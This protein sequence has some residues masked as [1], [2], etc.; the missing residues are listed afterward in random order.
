MYAATPVILAVMGATTLISAVTLL[1]LRHSPPSPSRQMATVVL[2]L[3]ILTAMLFFF[4][5]G[6][7][8]SPLMIAGAIV[9]Q[10]M[11][12][13][14]SAT[15]LHLV[16]LF[17]STGRQPSRPATLALAYSPA[18]FIT[19]L[20]AG[21]VT[22]MPGMFSSGGQS[23]FFHVTFG[24]LGPVVAAVGSIYLIASLVLLGLI[25][26]SGASGARWEMSLIFA[27]LAV[28]F[29]DAPLA[30]QPLPGF[31]PTAVPIVF[32]S[33]VGIALA[34]AV[35]RECP[36]IVPQREQGTGETPPE[37]KFLPGS[38]HLCLHRD[39]EMARKAFASVVK[40]GVQGLWVTRKNPRDGR[41]AQGLVNTP[42][43]WLTSATVEGEVCI[44][45][46]DTGRLS[47][48]FIDFLGAVKDYII[49]FEGLE[50]ITSNIGFKGTLNVLQFLNDK[51]MSSQGVLLV[52]LD[53][54]AFKP[55]E[56]AL[57]RSEAS[58]V[59]DESDGGCAPVMERAGVKDK[60]RMEK[61]RAG[62]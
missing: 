48:V 13:W 42:F 35:M 60:A 36:L 11:S 2:S 57:L 8:A 21:A 20:L 49:L 9:P 12:I 18:L 22:A 16:L 47:K 43:I 10:V 5:Y 6:G 26:R 15:M 45:P 39:R 58:A 19:V 34:Y 52:A 32:Q 7:A 56:M 28:T 27:L 30:L 3:L 23:D 61:S 17:H 53:A 59:H 55:E 29:L 33:L 14:V 51:V 25:I 4:S 41:T 46:S 62:V 50:Y 31:P 40:S 24:P 38:T 37:K 1:K 54:G 44:G